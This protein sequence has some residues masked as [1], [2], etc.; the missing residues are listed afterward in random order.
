MAYS[1]VAACVLLLKYEVDDP[2]MEE[3]VFDKGTGFINRITNNDRLTVPT[4]YTSGLATIL[5]SLY[6]FLC[7]CMAFVI[8]KM[9]SKILQADPLAITLLSLSIV[10]I[11]VTM[12]LL[13]RQP[14]SS[15]ILSFAVPFTPWFPA[16]SIMINL[17]LMVELDVATWIRF[18]IW[19]AIGLLIYVFYGRR[20]S[21]EK[22]RSLLNGSVEQAVDKIGY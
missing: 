9:G 12:F 2:E 22:E 16:L 5:V 6:G 11:V 19:I 10:A 3:Y 18:A 14:K 21:K 4:K 8:S 13:I 20:F 15:V 1:I 17:Y 7:L